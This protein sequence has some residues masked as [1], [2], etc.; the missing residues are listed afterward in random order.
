MPSRSSKTG[1]GFGATRWPT[2]RG[3]RPGDQTGSW[4]RPGAPYVAPLGSKGLV[5]LPPR[6]VQADPRRRHR[7]HRGR[8]LPSGPLQPRAL[9]RERGSRVLALPRR[10][11]RP[12]LLRPRAQPLLLGEQTRSDEVELALR[13]FEGGDRPR[14]DRG[15]DDPP[16]VLGRA[17]LLLLRRRRR[18][19]LGAEDAAEGETDDREGGEARGEGREPRRSGRGGE[20]AGDSVH[21]VSFSCGQGGAGRLAALLQMEQGAGVRHGVAERGHGDVVA[22]TLALPAH[23]GRDPPDGGMVEQGGLDDPLDEVDEVVVPPH[24]GEL[25]EQDALDLDGRQSRHQA[26]GEHHDG[27]EHAPGGGNLQPV[28]KKQR[29]ASAHAEPPGEDVEPRL[30]PARGGTG[31]ASP[32]PQVQQRSQET[33]A[34][35]G[36]PQGPRA[37]EDRQ[38]GLDG[39][40]SEDDR[41]GGR[42]SPD[43][44]RRGS[45]GRRETPSD[46]RRDRQGRQQGERPEREGVARAR[47]R[48]AGEEQRQGEERRHDR[49]FPDRMDEGP[50]E[51]LNHAPP[52]SRRASVGS[53]PAPPPR[54]ASR[55]G[56]A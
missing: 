2:P 34:Q 53:P 5:D 29:D 35:D 39:H 47:R 27:T 21:E 55:P 43:G 10:A 48:P 20:N 37:D 19:R 1:E 42:R 32:T 41:L 3:N 46:E 16:T 24:V 14:L 33:Q 9:L 44:R 49:A 18:L 30:V 12:L 36:D 11:V 15:R 23:D 38:P 56:R 17:E 50:A 51:T 6:V 45:R 28:G 7:G 26:R 22:E 54:R 4:P 25:V 8:D 40:G 31:V 52:P 13:A